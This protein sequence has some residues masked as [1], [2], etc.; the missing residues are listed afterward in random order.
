MS[1]GM[2]ISTLQQAAHVGCLTMLQLGIQRMQQCSGCRSLQ[3]TSI[4]Q[5]LTRQWLSKSSR[6]ALCCRP[7]HPAAVWSVLIAN[8]EAKHKVGVNSE[9]RT[10]I[11]HVWWCGWFIAFRQGAYRTTSRADCV[12]S[13][14]FCLE[15]PACVMQY[16]NCTEYASVCADKLLKVFLRC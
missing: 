7:F 16:P 3:R 9:I 2:Y 10:V 13:S 5:L 8:S 4:W 15:R 14:Y 6:T 1:T 11:C 12:C